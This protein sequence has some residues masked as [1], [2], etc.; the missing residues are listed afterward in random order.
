VGDHGELLPALVARVQ[1]RQL[2]DDPVE[3][4]E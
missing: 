3:P 2:V 4:C 1:A